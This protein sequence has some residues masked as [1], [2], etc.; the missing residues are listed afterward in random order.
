[1][2]ALGLHNERACG[3][4][5]ACPVMYNE[6]HCT[7]HS[8]MLSSLEQEHA[9]TFHTSVLRRP[10]S[11]DLRCLT[12]RSRIATWMF[13]HMY[14]LGFCLISV[15]PLSNISCR[16][17]VLSAIVRKQSSGVVAYPY[18][19]QV[20]PSNVLLSIVAALFWP[21]QSYAAEP[22]RIQQRQCKIL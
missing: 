8:R 22:A 4:T 6:A 12:R 3:S 10:K 14:L 15:S 17:A 16:A 18:P 7:H 9:D 20:C 19:S 5:L 11:T 13:L 1:M 2:Q 21:C